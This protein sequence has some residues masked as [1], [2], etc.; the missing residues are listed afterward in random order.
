MR[1]WPARC[2]SLRSCP[3]SPLARRLVRL[4]VSWRHCTRGLARESGAMVRIRSECLA[5][6]SPPARPRAT[7]QAAAHPAGSRST[8]RSRSHPR[9]FRP[10]PA[11]RLGTVNMGVPML[12]TRSTGPTTVP[13]HHGPP[14]ARRASSP[15]SPPPWP[16]SRRWP[17]AIHV[18]VVDEQQ[19]APARTV[20]PCSWPDHPTRHAPRRAE[21][22]AR[23]RH[24]L[25]ARH[26]VVEPG[27]CV[28]VPVRRVHDHQH[29]VTLAS[30]A[31]RMLCRVAGGVRMIV[32]TMIENETAERW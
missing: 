21:G 1:G 25:R 18:V 16:G 26:G 31:H 14:C 28:A 32:G 27:R 8:T 13:A 23:S 7:P 17:R 19:V 3:S 5:T 15:D 29:L 9:T 20:N 4:S 2:S 24:R 11:A 10:Y 6:H 22:C 30:P 12:P